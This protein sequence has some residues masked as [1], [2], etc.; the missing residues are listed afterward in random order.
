MEA[1]EKVSEPPAHY[2]YMTP[3]A[4][5][6]DRQRYARCCCDRAAATLLLLLMSQV[7]GWVGVGFVD[8]SLVKAP[9]VK[10]VCM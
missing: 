8:I 9:A 3:T 5:T 2:I 10:L 4:D 7:W 1:P 6:P